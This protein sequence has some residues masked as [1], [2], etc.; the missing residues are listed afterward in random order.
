MDSN[1]M[2]DLLW[3]SKQNH[4]F[5]DKEIAKFLISNTSKIMTLKLSIIAKNANCSTASVIKFCKKLG[6]KGLKDLLPALDRNYSYMQIQK[7]RFSNNKIASKNTTVSLYHSLI[8][9]NLDNLYK[10][11]HDSIIK[12]VALLKKVRHIIFFGKGSNLE[13]IQIFAN[14]LSKLQ[15]YVDYHYDFEVQQKWVEKSVDFSVCVFFS[16]SGMH[17]EI[18]RLV[19]TM[20]SKNCNIISFTSNYESNLFKQSSISFLTFKNEDV[21]EKHTSARIAFIYLIMQII[22]LLKN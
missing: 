13:I 6:F 5:I 10:I 19:Q 4:N 22:N 3:F 11:N 12:F 15:Y 8:S 16:F 17:L 7:S 20:K 1:L 2:N 21:L 14:Y 18:D 9:K